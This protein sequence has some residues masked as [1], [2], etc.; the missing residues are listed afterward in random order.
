M[1]DLN[2]IFETWLNTAELS[3]ENKSLLLADPIFRELYNNATHWQSQDKGY[4][5]TQVP[6]W[7]KERTWFEKSD[8]KSLVFNLNWLNSAMLAMSVLLSTLVVTNTQF[9][10]SEQGFSITFNQISKQEQQ[11]DDLKVMLSQIQQENGLQAWKMAQQAIDTGRTERREDINT[12]ITYLKDQRL[13]DQTL[14]K[15]QLNDLAEQ[16]EHQGSTT[17]AQNIIPEQ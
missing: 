15:L 12:L 2:K 7:D 17:I 13:Q 1:S 10:V 4:E 9:E 5:Q 3:E 14:I 11:L 8:T 6:Q 16:V